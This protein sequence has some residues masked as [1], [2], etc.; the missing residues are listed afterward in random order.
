MHPE[1]ASRPCV[2]ALELTSIFG[3]TYSKMRCRLNLAFYSS[4]VS[5]ASVLSPVLGPWIMFMGVLDFC[6]VVG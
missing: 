1:H 3:R 4:F 2:E 6:L 5:P